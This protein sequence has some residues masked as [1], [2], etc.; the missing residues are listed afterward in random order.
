M[1]FDFD[2]SVDEICKPRRVVYSRY[3]DDIFLSGNNKAVL[4]QCV[5]MVRLQVQTHRVPQL[6]LKEEKTLHLS[7]ANH[8]SVTGLVLTPQGSVS[9][10]RDRK[11]EIKTLI[12]LAVQGS[13]NFEQR[14]YISG[15]IAF[16]NDVEPD[17]VARINQKFGI[18]VMSLIKTL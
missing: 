6:R 11:R 13:L 15:L 5:Q 8:R 2:C 17:F 9:I 14:K 4:N 18:D 12:H 16:C 7:K 3:A 10:G 1:M